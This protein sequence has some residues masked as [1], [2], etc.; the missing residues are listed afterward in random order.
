[1]ILAC[2]AFGVSAIIIVI[3]GTKL[4]EFGDRL[5]RQTGLGGLWIGVVLMA[6]AT[7]LPEVLTTV[8][9][10]LLEAPDLIAG[11]LIGAGLT[12][13]LTLGIIDQVFRRQ[14]VWRHAATGHTVVA[15][16]AILLMGLTSLFILLKSN[17]TIFHVG[18]D[19]LILLLVYVL[20]MRV[21]FNYEMSSME[22][23]G[24]QE[25]AQKK[26]TVGGVGA[27]ERETIVGFSVSALAILC[28]APLLA[29][30]AERIAD[31][32]GISTSFI[33]TT[34]VAVTTSLPE[35]VTALAAVRIGAIDLAIGNLFGSN[36]FNIAAFATADLAYQPGPLLSAVS[37]THA[38]T[39]LWAVILMSL[40]LLGMVSRTDRRWVLIE[41]SSFLMILLYVLGIW[42]LFS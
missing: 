14:G 12:N 13:M 41:P 5:A 7:S 25:A 4:S 39:A 11:D 32:T 30:S 40:G 37:A 38:G 10:A 23:Q 20:G 22:M 18:A 16:V 31:A 35:M 33:G 28:S 24:S 36:A 2:I 34:L 3:S 17:V 29:W 15:A 19:S 27:V 9:A 26:V 6:G 21:V 42:L 1:M 8:S